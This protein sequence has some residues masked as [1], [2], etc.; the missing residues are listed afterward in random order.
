MSVEAITWALKQPIAQSSAKFVLVVLADAATCDTQLS[1][2]SVSYLAEAT[3]QDRKTVLA[4]LRRLQDMGYIQ[5]TGQ[6]RG[7]TKQIVVYRLNLDHRA[8]TAEAAP[9]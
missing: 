7:E 2:P 8:D 4:N 3:G 1:F 5:D 6:R 9:E